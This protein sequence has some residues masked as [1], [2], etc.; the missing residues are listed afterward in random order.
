VTDAGT[1]AAELPLSAYRPR[2][3]LVTSAHVP[4]RARH[5]VLDAHTHLGRWLSDWVGRAGQWLVGDVDE[6]LAAGEA[7]N[8]Q[9][10]VN[11]DG[12][13]G[14]ELEANLDRFDRSHPGRFATFC[15]PDWSLLLEPD[16][17]D[18][19]AEDLQRS[20]GAGAAGVKVW[21]DLGLG[22]ADTDGRLV[23]PDDPRLTP[24]WDAAA[25]AGLPVWWHV[26]DP[27]A[28]FRPIDGRNEAYEQLL[29]RPDWS[30]TDPRFPSFERL[31][32]AMERVVAGHPRTVFVAVHGGCYAE[33]LSWVGRM[34]DQHQNFHID[35]A[36]RIAQLGRQPRAFRELVVR[37]PDRVLF[38][39]DILPAI[40][41]GYAADTGV[42]EMYRRHFRFLETADEAFAHDSEEPSPA[43]RW[44]ISGVELPDGALQAVYGGN[45]ARLL[46]R[47]APALALGSSTAA[48]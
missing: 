25:E 36:A 46:P 43:G 45:T 1:G 41:S 44:T 33:N 13:F 19:I 10:F 22:I 12:R 2:S 30:F 5:P 31:I 18:R 29:A 21:K 26:A 6:W 34:L 47:L 4:D 20:A 8:V 39:S 16:G 9:G 48:R 24:M 42:R 7:V 17:P 38:G 23:L 14:D 27:V 32:L 37:H 40:P 15:H 35:I 11:L 3:E 28:F